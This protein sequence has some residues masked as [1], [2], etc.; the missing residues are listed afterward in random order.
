MDV[1]ALEAPS[2]LGLGDEELG[3]LAET[4]GVVDVEVRG[5]RER[6]VSDRSAKVKF[7]GPCMLMDPL[8]CLIRP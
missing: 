6:K 7:V 5:L 3:K 2:E 4:V 8:T 1:G